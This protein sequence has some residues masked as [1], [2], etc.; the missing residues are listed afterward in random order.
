MRVAFKTKTTKDELSYLS[1]QSHTLIK[2]F[3]SLINIDSK[4]WRTVSATIIAAE[5]HRGTIHAPQGHCPKTKAGSKRAAFRHHYN[6]KECLDLHLLKPAQAWAQM[7]TDHGPGSQQVLGVGGAPD[8]AADGEWVTYPY[9]EA[10]PILRWL[11]S[12]LAEWIGD[13]Y[14]AALG[15]PPKHHADG[16]TVG[17]L[18]AIHIPFSSNVS[19]WPHLCAH[20]NL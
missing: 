10:H 5:Y 19:Q 2:G 4:R 17:E 9:R 13:N 11:P 8:A 6:G 3:Q 18:N 7:A 12:K 20:F 16:W 14:G 15:I 1:R